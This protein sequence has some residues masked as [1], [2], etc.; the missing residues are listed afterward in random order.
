MVSRHNALA[1][2]LGTAI[3]SHAGAAA[4]QQQ[5]KA[6]PGTPPVD[7]GEVRAPD[8][9]TRAARVGGAA[10]ALDAERAE[11]IGDWAQALRLYERAYSQDADP[12]SIYRRILI[13][14]RIGDPNSGLRLL[15]ENRAQLTATERITDLAVVEERLRGPRRAASEAPAPVP[16]ASAMSW[17]LVGAGAALGVASGAA[18]WWAESRAERLACSTS[19]DRLPLCGGVAALGPYDEATYDEAARGVT[20]ARGLGWGGAVAGAGLIAWGA[21]QIVLSRERRAPGAALDVRLGPGSGELRA[22]WRF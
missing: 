4:G 7:S 15:E 18:L 11:E 5:W 16:P 20:I 6:A 17:A 1:L 22:S 10:I 21:A 13:Y 14:E 3:L 8:E 9:E 12:Y 2:A 19:S